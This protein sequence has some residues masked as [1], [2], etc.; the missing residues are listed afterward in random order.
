VIELPALGRVLL[1]V[2]LAIV[3]V[4]ILLIAGDRLPFVGRLPGDFV[5]KGDRW[6]FYAPLGTSILISV[7]LSLAL[8]LFGVL[9]GRRE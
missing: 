8:L 7:V 5:V 4:G 1:V 3:V 9:S 6:T 2:G